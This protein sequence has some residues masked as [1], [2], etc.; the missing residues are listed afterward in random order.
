MAPCSKRMAVTKRFNHE[1]A[2]EKPN[3]NKIL[4]HYVFEKAFVLIY[5]SLKLQ[6]ELDKYMNKINLN[7]IEEIPKHK[8]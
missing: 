7:K 4:C 1:K 8:R 6:I 3:S 5:Q 2:F